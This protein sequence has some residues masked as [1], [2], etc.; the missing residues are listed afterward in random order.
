MIIVILSRLAWIS[1]MLL[2]IFDP[3]HLLK[4]GITSHE[5]ATWL[6]LTGIWMIVSADQ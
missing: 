4:E 3:N 6:M 5:A 1:A 2:I